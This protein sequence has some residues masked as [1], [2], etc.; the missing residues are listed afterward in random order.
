[1]DDFPGNSKRAIKPSREQPAIAEKGTRLKKVV[2][3]EVVR[4][5]KPFGKRLKEMLVG[6]DGPTVWEYVMVDIFIPGIRDMFADIVT[7]GIERALYGESRSA[8]RRGGARFANPPGRVNYNGFASAPVGRAPVQ[9]PRPSLS[10][11]ARA[12]HDFEEILFPSRPDAEMVLDGL[13]AM[14]DQYQAVT[15]M[16]FYDL[17]GIS[18]NYTDERYGWTDLLGTRI[19]HTRHG[20]L[21]NLPPPILLER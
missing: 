10:R 13:Y 3:G 7:G 16:H 15:L 18:S 6:G 5:K 2:D 19:E 11:R 14:L 21:I 12:A 1:M 20:Y 17:A 8:H 9:D 4:R